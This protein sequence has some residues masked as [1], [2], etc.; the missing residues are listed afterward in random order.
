MAWTAWAARVLVHW[1]QSN[2]RSDKAPGQNV[3]LLHLIR[4][5]CFL[6]VNDLNIGSAANCAVALGTVDELN[7]TFS[8][9]VT[10][11]FR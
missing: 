4:R 10:H 5:I 2:R 9:M 7:A 8:L 1:K 3:T 11:T 6:R